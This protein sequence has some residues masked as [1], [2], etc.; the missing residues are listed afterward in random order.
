MWI[1]TLNFLRDGFRF[2]DKKKHKGGKKLSDG[3]IKSKNRV[4]CIK[5]KKK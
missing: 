4:K 3:E 2:D 5:I 1:F